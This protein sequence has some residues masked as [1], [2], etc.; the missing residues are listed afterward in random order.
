MP[1]NK[2]SGVNV[3]VCILSFNY[4]SKILPLLEKVKSQEYEGEVEII[5]IDSSND[6]SSLDVLKSVDGIRLESISN[7]EFGHGKT[8]NMAMSLA[9]GEIV[10]FLTQD[11][12]PTSDKW[13]DNIVKP[14]LTNEEVACV[15]GRQIPY[16]NCNPLVA[17]WINT[18]FNNISE[19]EVVYH[20]KGDGSPGTYFNSNV[21]SSYRRS[22]FDKHV[23]SFR[24][25][26][27]AEDQLIAHSIIN[28]GLMT[29]YSP[30]AAVYHSHS[31]NRSYEYFQR[32]FDEF[33]GYKD[34]LGFVDHDVNLA[35]LIPR[36][37]RELSRDIGF[38]I[39]SIN[40][41]VLDKLV[42]IIKAP[43]VDFY[44]LMGMFWGSRNEFVPQWIKNYF[45]SEDMRRIMNTPKAT[46]SIRIK[47]TTLILY[48]L[49]RIIISR[50]L[51]GFAFLR[52]MIGKFGFRFGI[53]MFYRGYILR[54][55][56]LPSRVNLEGG[57]YS[58]VMNDNP[59]KETKVLTASGNK[60]MKEIS[61][62]IPG[63]TMSSG[64]HTDIFRI[65]NYLEKKG[66]I[67]KFYIIPPYDWRIDTE[68][69]RT[70]NKYFFEF[71]KAEVHL[72][73]GPDTIIPDANILV[74]TSWQT[75]YYGLNVLAQKK[76]YFVQD[77]EPY[78]AAMGTEYLLAERT[79]H[80][81]YTYLA[82]SPWL[83]L[84]LKS[85]YSME[86]TGLY[87]GVDHSEY[88]VSKQFEERDKAICFYSRAHSPRRGVE[89]GSMALALVQNEIPDLKIYLFGDENYTP[90]V[91][92]EYINKGLLKR[93]E[94]NKLFNSCQLG[95]AFSLTN[96]SIIPQEMN[97]SGLP[98]IDIDW[99]GN[100]VN[101]NGRDAVLLSQ[102]NPY[103]IAKLIVEQIQNPIRLKRLSEQAATESMNYKWD[104][105]FEIFLESIEK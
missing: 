52:E 101:Y 89:V 68:A 65:A 61:W 51:M 56:Y 59:L 3:T 78:F 23:I 32:F 34:T 25:V 10:A 1:K 12:I 62:I 58:F 91:K 99:E 15:Y 36:Y 74:V 33:R 70:I 69:L 28:S 96:Y 46:L 2:Q 87:I 30:H 79:Y 7:S 43:I 6:N 26:D 49:A 54:K 95:M 77:F 24:D 63:F 27:Y 47:G 64:G 20:K 100:R 85:E 57:K 29:A 97:A 38:T 60:N 9:K 84:K 73:K 35:N 88:S 5:V 53:S 67:N 92:F 41:P 19:G 14:F 37:L 8:R 102:F 21:N 50:F 104:K 80:M 71:K 81:G 103:S 40:K 31:W 4:E 17:S 86:G 48:M 18:A 39:T 75:A 105:V 82:L 44:K 42:W 22:F 13:L 11:A 76:F 72:L 90:D 98:V 83:D 93:E 45:S 66:Y 55:G 16:H 94:L